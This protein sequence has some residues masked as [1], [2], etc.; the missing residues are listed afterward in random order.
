MSVA[1]KYA[2]ANSGLTF[3]PDKNTVLWLPGQDDAYSATIRDRSGRGN[4]GTI[5][6]ATWTR[7]SQR[8]WY[9]DYDGIDD[10]TTVSDSTS[11]QNIWDGGGTLDMW[12]RPDSDGE[13]DA[14]RVVSKNEIWYVYNA[15]E[16]GGGVRFYFKHLFSGTDI[17]WRTTSSVFIIG[18]WCKFTLTYNSSSTANQPIFFRN[19]V[20]VSRVQ[21]IG[22]PTGTRTTDAGSDLYLGNHSGTSSTFDG[23]QTIPKAATVIKTDALILDEFNQERHLFGV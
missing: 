13:A 10:I 11:I 19:G 17:E 6:G 15:I 8:T 4:N 7:N 1:L 12:V 20:A 14:G 9:L 21:S 22:P 2:R 5:V 3:R 23:G 18:E 16:S